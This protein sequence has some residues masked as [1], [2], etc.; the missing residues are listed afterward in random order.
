MA[1]SWITP[2]TTK[3]GKPRYRVEWRLGGRESATRYGGSFR[4][5][6]EAIAR[7]R[8]ID[9]ELAA[10]RVPDIHSLAVEPERLPTLAEAAQRW[11]ASRVDVSENTR[12]QHRSAVRAAVRELGSRRV[13]AITPTDV[14]A[15]VA[16]LAERG[17]KRETIRKVL[18]ALGMVLDHAGI[19]PNP[20]RDKTHVRLPRGDSPEIVPPTAE[21]VLAV[22]DLL[23]SRYRLPLLVLDATGMRLGELQGLRWGDVDEHAGA[24]ASP[25]PCRRLAPVAGCRCRR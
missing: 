9:G 11:M 1:S 22:H 7:R 14:V 10:L 21:Q 15:L 20:T 19:S 3:S 17:R 5:K 12:L 4:T 6:A 2:R 18:L 23:P 13:D 25:R 16:T 24:G 8:W